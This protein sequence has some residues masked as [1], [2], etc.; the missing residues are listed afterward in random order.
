M[1]YFSICTHMASSSRRRS[2]PS[3]RASVGSMS[4]ST[5]S[6]NTSGV[7]SPRC[8]AWV[9]TCA[10]SESVSL[11][12][13]PASLGPCASGGSRSCGLCAKWRSGIRLAIRAGSSSAASGGGEGEWPVPPGRAAL[14]SARNG[15]GAAARN[16]LVFA[17]PTNGLVLRGPGSST[18]AGCTALEKTATWATGIGTMSRL[19]FSTTSRGGLS[20][21]TAGAPRFGFAKVATVESR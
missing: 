11:I 2:P 19:R 12:G 6:P 16:G 10:G 7:C 8:C 4:S 14:L 1:Q 15:L 9:C 17:R 13:I 20:T 3:E 21:R 18:A 5:W